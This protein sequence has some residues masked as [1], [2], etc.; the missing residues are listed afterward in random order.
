[1]QGL[2]W[3]EGPAEACA[4]LEMITFSIDPQW[5]GLLFSLYCRHEKGFLLGGGGLPQHD[6]F[7]ACSLAGPPLD[8]DWIAIA[9]S[10]GFEICRLSSSWAL[11]LES[12]KATGV[13]L[14]LGVGSLVCYRI[15]N[16]YW[17]QVRPRSRPRPQDPP[18]ESDDQ[19]VED[20]EDE[21]PEELEGRYFGPTLGASD[22]Y[23]SLNVDRS[24]PCSRSASGSIYPNSSTSQSDSGTSGEDESRDADVSDGSQGDK[25]PKQVEHFDSKHQ[26]KHWSGRCSRISSLD[27]NNSGWLMD[28]ISKILTSTPDRLQLSGS[29][30]VKLPS[31]PGQSLRLSRVENRR[32]GPDK[33]HDRL[34]R[35]NSEGAERE[36]QQ[37]SAD[38]ESNGTSW[39]QNLH[40]SGTIPRDESYDSLGFSKRLPREGS[41]DSTCSELSLDF[42]LPESSV[43][44]ETGTMLC[45]EKLQQEIDQLKTNCLMMDEEFETIKCNRNLPGMSSLM[46]VSASDAMD[47]NPDVDANTQESLKQEKARACFAG[48]YS[49]TTIKNSTSSELSDS[50]PAPV[51]GLGA[52]GS[53]G[54]AESLDWDS[55]KIVASPAKHSLDELTE[56]LEDVSK[57]K[58]NLSNPPKTQ[59]SRLISEKSLAS[60]D[61]L[62]ANLEWD[63]EDMMEYPE[64]E[65][66]MVILN[67]LN[68]SETGSRSVTASPATER[69]KM[70]SSS[71]FES[72]SRMLD[73]CTSMQSD[74][75]TRKSW[76]CWSS[77]ESGCMNWDATIAATV[78]N[79]PTS[80]FSQQS[81]SSNVSEMST[82][83]SENPPSDLS[84]PLAMTENVGKK[85]NVFQYAVREWQGNT[86]KAKTILQGYSE[87]PSLLGLQNLRRIR[88]DNYC[89][90][91]AAIF[92]TLSQ[93]LPVPSGAETFQC[94]SHALNSEG[95]GWLQDWTFAGRLPYEGNKVLQGMEICLRNLDNVASLL[96]S[97]T[98]NK[99]DA[100]A[101]L[102][103]CDPTLDLHIVEAVKLHMLW[104]AMQLHRQNSSGTDEVPL[105]A[106]LM[107]ARDTS[108]T[109]RDLMNNHL[110]D[111]GST[112]G[113]EQEF[114]NLRI[115][116]MFLLPHLISFFFY[117]AVSELIS[118]II[119]KKKTAKKRH[120][121]VLELISI[122]SSLWSTSVMSFLGGFLLTC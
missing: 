6:A 31:S 67:S 119:S 3:H 110:R 120:N 7:A 33:G 57:S 109:P 87:I 10:V 30:W 88:G 72:G 60:E 65:D 49:L 89:G 104:Q 44:V 74:S 29:A 37:G 25:S 61:E 26:S 59:L 90:V 107:F 8:A 55:P 17:P 56:D 112:G 118:I 15:Y 105:F 9:G 64:V 96:S 86:R 13:I 1:M 114:Q 40:S 81:Y 35:L 53:I 20:I 34:R 94:L 108:E 84:S 80:A 11:I 83:A 103:N 70:E 73:S 48:L 98:G 93:G 50:F 28:K 12:V 16:R 52:R 39:A 71:G 18:Q 32:E 46:K 45:M 14:L 69:S 97:V 100:L 102:L 47:V 2:R 68:V 38:C 4:Q 78:E 66:S 117:T 58:V 75:A 51:R 5:C 63:E 24:F 99:E 19:L 79:P 92:Q 91:R 121:T 101:A 77:E 106:M 122:V 116:L 27:A 43:D 22:E 21:D 54:S 82:P 42:S 76:T 41:F 95:C 23:P 85:V 113:L 36:R 115:K 111:V 62:M